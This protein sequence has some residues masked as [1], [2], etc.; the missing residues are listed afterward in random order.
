[1]A[2]LATEGWLVRDLDWYG[3]SPDGADWTG[4]DRLGDASGRMVRGFDSLVGVLIG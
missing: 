4:N 1:M 2:R 3:Y